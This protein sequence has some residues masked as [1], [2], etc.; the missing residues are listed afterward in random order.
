M[1]DIADDAL[2]EIFCEIVYYISDTNLGTILDWIWDERLN[3]RKAKHL[4]R[5]AELGKTRN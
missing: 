5:G 2:D 1:D 3:N 4:E